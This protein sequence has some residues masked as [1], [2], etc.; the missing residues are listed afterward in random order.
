MKNIK[1]QIIKELAKAFKGKSNSDLEIVDY[2]I[3]KDYID[4]SIKVF[5]QNKE[6][7]FNYHSAIVGVLVFRYS[8]VVKLVSVRGE[9]SHPTFISINDMLLIKNVLE[10][11]FKGCNND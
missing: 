7:T 4:L 5:E 11:F 10:I 9:L 1:Q 2:S 8:N 3:S 6:K